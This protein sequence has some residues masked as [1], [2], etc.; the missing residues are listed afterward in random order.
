MTIHRSVRAYFALNIAVVFH[1]SISTHYVLSALQ[2]SKSCLAMAP[3]GAPHNTTAS[4][5]AVNV[6]SVGTLTVLIGAPVRH[7]PRCCRQ[8]Q[9]ESPTLGA[10]VKFDSIGRVTVRI[11][12][13]PRGHTDIHTMLVAAPRLL[14]SRC[15]TALRSEHHAALWPP[16]ASLYPPLA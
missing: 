1:F 11:R 5:T 14:T 9:C 10:P 12:H 6:A 13:S 15:S 4:A 3:I 2:R 7:F 16:L 8:V